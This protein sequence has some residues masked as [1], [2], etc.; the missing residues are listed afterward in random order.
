MS[1]K[2]VSAI[3]SALGVLMTI[4]SELVAL[5]RQFGGQDEDIHRLATP[6]GRSALEQVARLIVETGRKTRSAFHLL[7][8]HD[9]SVEDGVRAGH[10]DWSN[11]NITSS[12]FPS[13]R[14]GSEEVD[15][16]LVHFNQVMSTDQVL[17]E[18]DKVG[19]KP[20]DH[21]H[22]L[23]FGEKFP[24]VQRQF[25]IV[26]LGSSWR[27]PVGGHDC[28]CL[29]RDGAGRGLGLRWI[30]GDWG[31]RCRFAAVSK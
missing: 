31:G 28:V 5:V 8:N 4:I 26:F 18:L 2:N 29:D 12:H 6:E 20:A 17:A 10:Y 22:A 14:K 23:A 16:H 15:V 19:L 24:D 1:K 21:N 25:P 30:D 3:I 9:R 11:S 13:N 27:G 7:V